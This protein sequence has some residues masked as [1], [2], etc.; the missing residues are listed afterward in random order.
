MSCSSQDTRLVSRAE[1]FNK[2][3]KSQQDEVVDASV[4]ND[5]FCVKN[6]NIRKWKTSLQTST[7]HLLIAVVSCTWQNV[8]CLADEVFLE[9]VMIVSRSARKLWWFL[10]PP[11]RIFCCLCV[12][13]ESHLPPSQNAVLASWLGGWPGDA[14]MATCQAQDGDGL[15]AMVEDYK[16]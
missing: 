4:G 10:W 11:Q 2:K 9:H 8:S 13:M 14:T 12:E 7:V 15:R 16:G 1:G 5:A 6:I 3:D